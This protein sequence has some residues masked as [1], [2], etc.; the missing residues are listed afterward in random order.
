M[1][2]TS[3]RDYIF[4]LS[5]V[6]FASHCLA[7]H[8]WK[9][10]ANHV[11]SVSIINQSDREICEGYFVNVVLMDKEHDKIVDE[12]HKLDINTTYE[13]G[14]ETFMVRS[15][16]I[17]MLPA[18]ERILFCLHEVKRLLILPIPFLMT[19]LP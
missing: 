6:R 17:P 8:N 16:Q 5:P 3:N 13:C 10:R 1:I 15:D 2:V 7:F 11:S 4:Y 18:H 14:Q 9:I 19:D 12:V